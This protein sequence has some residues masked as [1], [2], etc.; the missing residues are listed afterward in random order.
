MAYAGEHGKVAV[1]DSE[2]GTYVVVDGIRSLSN[3]KNREMLDTTDFKD[4]EGAVDRIAGLMDGSVDISGDFE[5]DDPGLQAIEEAFDNGEKIWVRCTV[6][7]DATKGFK[8]AYLVESFNL[9]D[10][11]DGKAEVSVTFQLAGKRPIRL[12]TS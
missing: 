1:S 6:D 10:S 5:P 3:P 4:N 2:N 12:P 9:D 7:P 11:V 8:A